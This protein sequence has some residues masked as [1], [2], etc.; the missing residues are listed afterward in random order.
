[1][2]LHFT[3]STHNGTGQTSP[4]SKNIIITGWP[5][6]KEDLHMDIRPYW[7]YR[8]DLPVIYGVVMKGRCIIIPAELKHQVSDQLH[9]N[10]MGIDKTKAL[11]HESIYW[12]NINTDKEMHIKSFLVPACLS[13]L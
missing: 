6:T 3:D 7:S 11:M 13:G 10:H 8:D 12:V 5:S 4:T 9:L 2:H 1:M